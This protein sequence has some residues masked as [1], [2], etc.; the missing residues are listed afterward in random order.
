MKTSAPGDG[1]RAGDSE[2]RTGTVVISLDAELAW[3]LH[4]LHPLSTAEERRVSLAR[5]AWSRLVELFDEHGMPATWAIVGALLVEDDD[6]FQDEHPLSDHWFSTYRDDVS[7]RPEQ[8]RGTDLVQ[9]VVDSDVQHE[10]GCHSFS[11]V[12]FPDV[13]ADVAR[14]ECR[15]ARTVG[16]RYGLEFTSFVFPRNE[17]GH[18]AALSETGFDCY[19]GRRPHRLPAIP[20][21]RGG[22]ALAGGLTKT[23]GSPIAIPRIDQHGL[24]EI[25]SSLFIGKRQGGLGSAIS[26]LA[27]DP[28]LRL[29][30]LGIDEAAR[31][32]GLFHVWLHPND[33]TEEPEVRRIETL[34]SYLATRRDAG[35]VRVETMGEVA[36][37]VLQGDEGAITARTVR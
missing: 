2:G 33:I 20:G 31:T 14:A 6:E 32:G 9:A 5:P 24:V 35:D 21:L 4:D 3:G 8:W 15:L 1:S 37:R 12:V 22:A 34:L 7:E 25:P 19:R 13:S 28:T 26:A 11:H 29:A 30:R 10:V 16:E 27:E 17:I 18:R 36:Q 23:A